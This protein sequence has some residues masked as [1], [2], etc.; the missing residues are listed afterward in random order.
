MRS[1]NPLIII[2]L[3]ALFGA[4]NAQ[5]ERCWSSGSLALYPTSPYSGVGASSMPGSWYLI[6]T[7]AAFGF[8]Q[9]NCDSDAAN[10]SSA[11]AFGP[12]SLRPTNCERKMSASR[13]VLEAA[14]ASVAAKF[15]A[16]TE[17]GC[18]FTCGD[19]VCRMNGAS[20]LPVELMSFS[21]DDGGRWRRS[22]CGIQPACANDH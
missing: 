10:N 4:Q 14:W 1:K 3:F 22:A 9:A 12:A 6:D 11:S 15:A 2:V 21:V 5:A 7:G 20:G 18:E 17:A 8:A 13:I 16:G 19:K